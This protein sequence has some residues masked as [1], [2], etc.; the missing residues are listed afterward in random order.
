MPDAFSSTAL[1]H[2]LFM[3]LNI[4]DFWMIFWKITVV[5]LSK[6]PYQ[7]LASLR[8]FLF[9]IWVIHSTLN[10]GLFHKSPNYAWSML[11]K[12]WTTWFARQSMFSSVVKLTEEVLKAINYEAKSRV[13]YC[14]FTGCQGAPAPAREGLTRGRGQQMGPA[15]LPYTATQAPALTAPAQIC[16]KTSVE[17]GKTTV[18]QKY[19]TLFAWA[20]NCERPCFKRKELIHQY[21]STRQH[22]GT[23]SWKDENKAKG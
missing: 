4:Y 20:F 10:R 11:V 13:R 16:L 17:K 21:F 23:G 12:H 5:G 22:A 19:L 15:V 6:F 8:C 9:Y 3:T 7:L 2:L 18:L 1:E 14:M